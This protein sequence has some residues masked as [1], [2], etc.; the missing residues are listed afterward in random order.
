MLEFAER[1]AIQPWVEVGK[2]DL[3]GIREGVERLRKGLTRYRYG[4]HCPPLK[5]GLW[6]LRRAVQL[7]KISVA[8][9]DHQ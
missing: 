1:H 7:N 6:P 4:Y 8:Q 9:A 3:E 2:S 5:I